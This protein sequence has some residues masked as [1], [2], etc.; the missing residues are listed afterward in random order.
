M[1]VNDRLKGK[2]GFVFQLTRTVDKVS[3]RFLKHIEGSDGLYEI[4][5][6]AVYNSETMKMAVKI[7]DRLVQQGDYEEFLTLRACDLVS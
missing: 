7:L 2:I 1:E 4:R 5:I 3:E 6:E